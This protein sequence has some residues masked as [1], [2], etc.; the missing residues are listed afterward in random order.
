[1]ITIRDDKK[2]AR[3]RL[4]GQVASFAGM[5]ALIG[6]MAL[7]FFGDPQRVFWLQITALFVGWLLSQV[8]IYYSQRFFRRPRPDEVLDEALE[9]LA[10]NGRLYHYSLPTP[11]VLLLPSGIIIFIAKY[12]GGKISVEGDKWKQSG[13]GLR[14]IFG[15]EGIGNPSKEAAQAIGALADFLKK[16]AP[17]VAEVPIGAMIVFT[18][19]GV[20]DLDLKGSDIPAMH[21]TKIKGYLKQKKRAKDLP[22]Y[23]YEALRD[24]FDQKARVTD[25]Q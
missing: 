21:Y 19:K 8:G 13:T 15:Q 2:I 1:M 20:Y 14:R 17:S 7:V 9:K 25:D 6:G 22:H 16:N 4:L 3:L 23:D 11:H 18:T 24:A 10:R 12:Q 5:A